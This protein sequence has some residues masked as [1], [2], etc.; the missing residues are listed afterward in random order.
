MTGRFA[1]TTAGSALVT[2]LREAFPHPRMLAWLAGL[3]LVILAH[4][5]DLVTF[6]HDVAIIGVNPEGNPLARFIYQNAGLVGMTAFKMGMLSLVFATMLALRR[7][8]SR[9]IVIIMA[10]I[11]G[12]VGAIANMEALAVYYAAAGTTH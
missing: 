6:A 3:S 2:W 12:L 10:A 4:L 7:D 9:V 1:S 8:R 5:A 11:F